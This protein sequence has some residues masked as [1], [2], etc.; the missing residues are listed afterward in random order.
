MDSATKTA[1]VIALLFFISGPVAAAVG[2]ANGQQ[3]RA[4]LQARVPVANAPPPRATILSRPQ[5]RNAW[6]STDQVHIK[7]NLPRGL[8]MIPWQNPPPV[9]VNKVVDPQARQPAPSQ[10]Q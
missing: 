2:P 3:S 1:A 8:T 7:R 10:N 5:A 9:W 6:K 4:T